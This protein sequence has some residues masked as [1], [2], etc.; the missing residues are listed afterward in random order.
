M[1]LLPLI[2]A[3]TAGFSVAAGYAIWKVRKLLTD[4]TDHAFK[5]A[6]S[7]YQCW[8]LFCDEC[9]QLAAPWWKP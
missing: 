1:T 3:F 5:Q 9:K 7:R 8:Q 4:H 6:T 2:A